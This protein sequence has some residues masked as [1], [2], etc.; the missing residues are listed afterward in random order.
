MNLNQKAL[1]AAAKALGPLADENRD[2]SAAEAAIKAYFAELAANGVVVEG[3]GWWPPGQGEGPDWTYE[4]AP[5]RLVFD[6]E[7]INVSVAS[8]EG[9]ERIG[10]CSVP[11]AGLA[12]CFLAA[13]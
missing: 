4:E 5:L 12:L 3:G 10:L 6:G 9:A 1:E 7:C 11:M 2:V 8:D 13:D